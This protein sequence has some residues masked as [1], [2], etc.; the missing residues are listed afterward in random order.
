MRERKKK[1][2][3]SV[4][5]LASEQI[6]KG[7][8]EDRRQGDNREGENREEE[9]RIELNGKRDRDRDGYVVKINTKQEELVRKAER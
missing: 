1:S 4:E 9:N 7:Y 5:K 3:K 8:K 2:T 6:W